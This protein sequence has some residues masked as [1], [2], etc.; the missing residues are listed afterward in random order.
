MS[1]RWANLQPSPSALSRVAAIEKACVLKCK[2]T[3]ET[4]FDTGFTISNGLAIR[5]PNLIPRTQ[6][7][8]TT[9]NFLDGHLYPENQQPLIIT[10]A[11]Y[12]PDSC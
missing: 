9:M 5:D 6:P 2:V 4:A 1:R 8:T 12:A 10:A 7:E 11:P 3:L